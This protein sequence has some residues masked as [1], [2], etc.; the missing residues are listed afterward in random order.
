QLAELMADWSLADSAAQELLRYLSFAQVT[1]PRYAR[2]DTEFYGQPIRR[3][4]IVVGC[5]ATANSD[6][7]VFDHPD[8][9]DLHPHPNRHPP[10]T[11][12][13]PVTLPSALASTFVLAP[14]SPASRPPSLSSASSPASP[15]SGLPFRAPRSGSPP[16]SAAAPSSRFRSNS[17]RGGIDRQQVAG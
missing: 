11:A 17:D 15:T 4:Q 7:S 14:S 2:E 5:L 6:P 13:R 12:S 10:S 1:K 9:L 3:G 16:A 8:R